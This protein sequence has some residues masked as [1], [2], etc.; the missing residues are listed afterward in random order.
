VLVDLKDATLTRI[1]DA[2]LV[3]VMIHSPGYPG[4]ILYDELLIVTG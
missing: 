3:I 2:Q 4:L 1:N